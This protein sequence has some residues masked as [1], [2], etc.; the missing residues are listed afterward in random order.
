MQKFSGNGVVFLE[1]DGSVVEKT[2]APGEKL[3]VDTG[4]VAAMEGTCSMEIQT[5]KGVA[6]VLVGGEG[7]F[8]TVVTGPGKVWLQTMPISRMADAIAAHIPSSN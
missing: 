3:I 6:N 2:L 7:L 1:V 4:Y 8:N 5:V